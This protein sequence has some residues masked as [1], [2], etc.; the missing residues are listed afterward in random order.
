MC[1]CVFIQ[2]RGRVKVKDINLLKVADKMK[3]RNRSMTMLFAT[4]TTIDVV[5]L[6]MIIKAWI[7]HS[8]D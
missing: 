2:L 7:S 6:Q 5:F 4:I 8:L 1:V 3:F